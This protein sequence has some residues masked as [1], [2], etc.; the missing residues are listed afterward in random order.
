MHAGSEEN[1]PPAPMS[2]ACPVCETASFLP[3]REISSSLEEIPEGLDRGRSVL[4]RVEYCRQCGLY[5]TVHISEQRSAATLYEE[6]SVSFDAS[7]DK[8]DHAGGRC[9]SSTD[10]F[11]LLSRKLP[12]SLLDVGCGAGQFLL[13]ACDA[14]HEAMGVD[15]DPRAVR[16]A[17]EELGMDVRRGSLEELDDERVF[18]VITL[19]GVLEHVARPK[20]FLEKT[21][22]LLAPGGELVIGVPNV[23]SLNRR[24][25][26]LSRHDW[27]MFL[28]PGHLYHY[29]LRTLTS[30]ASQAGLE[31]RRWSTATIT[32]RGKIPFAPVRVV[33]LERQIRDMTSASRLAESV[34]V[35]CLR[36]LDLWRAG[37]ILLATYKER[38]ADV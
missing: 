37:D 33:K 25:S 31:L 2:T 3:Y 4:A 35:A 34:Y 27:D 12:G 21:R 28:E 32:I 6:D 22:Q 19:F 7:R 30:L 16:F 14:G 18:D 29:N 17:R 5:R 15:L 38:I 13:R 36:F 8:V 9:I 23:A 10:E 1:I 20:R 11:A 26:R 24:V